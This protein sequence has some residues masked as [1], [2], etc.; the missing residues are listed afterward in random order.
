MR[1]E[2][3]LNGL[4]VLTVNAAFQRANVFVTNPDETTKQDFKTKLKLWVIEIA[5]EYK[6]NQVSEVAH[7]ENIKRLESQ[8]KIFSEILT[9]GRL[10]F[11]VS[12][13]LL[14]IYLKHLW[15]MDELKFPP[16]HFPVDRIIQKELKLNPKAWTQME[17]EKDYMVVINRAREVLPN[18]DVTNIAELELHLYSIVRY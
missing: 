15:C 14:N 10:N 4:W 2:F 9:Y 11:G 17:D 12:Q 3:I 7:I 18:Y 8:T 16:P 5:E 13:K 1:R 6:T